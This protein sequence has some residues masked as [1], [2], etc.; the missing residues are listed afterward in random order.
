MNRQQSLSFS[1][2]L[3]LL[4]PF[5]ASAQGNFYFSAGVTDV[6]DG[7]GNQPAATTTLGYTHPINPFLLADVSY[8]TT[9]SGGA[10]F[11][12]DD[13]S[14]LVLKYDTYNLGLKLEQDLGGYVIVNGRA[15]ASYSK[16]EKTSFDGVSLTTT[17]TDAS[18]RPYASIGADIPAPVQEALRLKFDVIYQQLAAGYHSINYVLGAS[19]SY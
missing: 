11:N 19:I 7:S 12:Y 1:M 14:S 8:T 3:L 15:G 9:L 6:H 10:K 4:V 5:F 18:I 13:G 16:L 17:D 2:L